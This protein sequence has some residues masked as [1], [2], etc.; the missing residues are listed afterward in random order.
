MHLRNFF[1]EI[2]NFFEIIISVLDPSTIGTAKLRRAG[3]RDL[4]AAAG[5]MDLQAAAGMMDPPPLEATGIR[6]R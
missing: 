4:Q 3:T 5:M 6:Y 1:F 2:L